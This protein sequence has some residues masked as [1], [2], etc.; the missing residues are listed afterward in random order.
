MQSRKER[1][2]AIS[3]ENLGYL[4]EENVR[5]AAESESFFAKRAALPGKGA[6]KTAHPGEKSV[7][8]LLTTKP[9]PMERVRLQVRNYAIR[10]SCKVTFAVLLALTIGV[11]T[12]LLIGLQEPS[13]LDNPVLSRRELKSGTRD[14]EK[15]QLEISDMGID[16]EEHLRVTVKNRTSIGLDLVNIFWNFFGKT[17]DQI[18][19]EWSDGFPLT[20]LTTE[21]MDSDSNVVPAGNS[22]TFVNPLI[23]V[24]RIFAGISLETVEAAEIRIYISSKAFYELNLSSDVENEEIDIRKVFQSA[25]FPLHRGLE[26]VSPKQMPPAVDSPGRL[27]RDVPVS[28]G[29]HAVDHFLLPDSPN[30]DYRLGLTTGERKGLGWIEM[31]SVHDVLSQCG[32]GYLEVMSGYKEPVDDEK[33]GPG[34]LMFVRCISKKEKDDYN[35]R[36]WVSTDWKQGRIISLRKRGE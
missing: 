1:L 11:G 8:Q 31:T 27:R 6:S 2:A 22:K 4:A 26:A 23:P 3:Q 20:V 17:G 28:T 29:G 33:D 10:R 36:I 12:G 32:R 13:N 24:D 7:D 19:S 14:R 35:V 16:N 15:V 18:M 34:W 30:P 9:Q 25:R 5:L 21:P